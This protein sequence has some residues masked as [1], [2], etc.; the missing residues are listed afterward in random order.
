[1]STTTE[2]T[3]LSRR[4]TTYAVAGLVVA[5]VIIF[6]GNYRVEKGENGGLGPAIITAVGCLIVTAVIYALVLP[7]TQRPDR[8]AVILGVL[9]VLS[10]VVFW[11]G[12]TPVLAAGAF[13]ATRDRDDVSRGVRAAQI[14]GAV[15]AV[16]A[17]VVTLYQSHLF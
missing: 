9:A 17:L 15:A 1:M 12:M 6:A 11:S 16:L 13:A 4:L 14:A 3:A 8:T 2:Q 5:A 10:L 7:R